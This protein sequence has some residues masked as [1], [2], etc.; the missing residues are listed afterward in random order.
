MANC[1]LE[2][3][4]AEKSTGNINVIIKHSTVVFKGYRK[5][6]S[7]TFIWIIIFRPLYKSYNS[8]ISYSPSEL[9]GP[10]IVLNIFFSKVLIMFSSVLVKT[11]VSDA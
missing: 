5:N 1:L 9:T 8:V 3:V 11:H 10:K 4:P 6:Q 7:P 2:R